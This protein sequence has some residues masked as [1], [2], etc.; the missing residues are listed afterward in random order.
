MP[1]T[2]V[3]HLERITGW[4]RGTRFGQQF[5]GPLDEFRWRRVDLLVVGA[6]CIPEVS[7]LPWPQHPSAWMCHHITPF[8]PAAVD[9]SP[10]R[11]HQSVD[12]VRPELEG[13]PARE[14]CESARRLDKAVEPLGSEQRLVHGDRQIDED[15]PFLPGAW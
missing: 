14:P 8:D 13:G 5:T 11:H 2:P 1:I 9:L 4:R 3:R 6:Q 10:G 7:E 15:P 12:P